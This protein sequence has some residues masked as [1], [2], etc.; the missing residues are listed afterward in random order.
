M[1]KAIKTPLIVLCVIVGLIVV[2]ALAAYLF[3]TFYPSVGK[4][5]DS[6]AKKMYEEI[7]ENFYDGEFHNENAFEVMTGKQQETSDRQIPENKIE[8]VA[9]DI[10]KRAEDNKLTVTWFGHSSSLI[11]ALPSGEIRSLL[12]LSSISLKTS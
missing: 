10:S 7:A 8:S 1:R 4:M 3:L 2:V 6:E 9:P 5:P 11:R 12:H